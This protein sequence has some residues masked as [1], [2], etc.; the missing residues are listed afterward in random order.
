MW[1]I[2]FEWIVRVDGSRR[3]SSLMCVN[4]QHHGQLYSVFTLCAKFPV[5]SNHQ[6]FDEYI[7][8]PPQSPNV[9]H[10]HSESLRVQ[11]KPHL[12]P[13]PYTRS[14]RNNYPFD[15][16]GQPSYQTH[17]C[18]ALSGLTFELEGAASA[19][20]TVKPACVCCHAES[21]Q[22][23]RWPMYHCNTAGSNKQ[24]QVPSPRMIHSINHVINRSAGTGIA[25]FVLMNES[26][27]L[28]CFSKY[29]VFK[30]WIVEHIKNR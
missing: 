6:H 22:R 29:I 25:G 11:E 26:F 27:P 7:Y 14:V 13:D 10:L 15:R 5:Q 23:K 28:I 4:F 12:R 30:G 24:K 19:F 20:S 2:S 17:S 18:T 9:T 16:C 21:L 1:I 3:H 8:L